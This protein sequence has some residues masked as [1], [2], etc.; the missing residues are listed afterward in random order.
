MTL[1]A[2]RAHAPVSAA[3]AV[4]RAV[5]SRD[6][7]RRPRTRSALTRWP[8]M[9]SA[10][11]STVSALIIATPTAAMP[12]SAIDLRKTS[13]K[14]SRQA[15]DQDR[16][17]GRGHRPRHRLTRR[18]ARAEFLAETVDH[19]QRVVDRHAKAEQRY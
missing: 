9:A 8:S 10:A 2:S 1:R 6:C 11:G 17:A 18:T 3:S 5:A 13:G 14:I 19:E 7:R 4:V 15:G 12:P 16:A